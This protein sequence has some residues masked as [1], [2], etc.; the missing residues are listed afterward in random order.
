MLVLQPPGANIPWFSG[1]TAVLCCCCWGISRVCCH[2][3][4]LSRGLTSAP[5]C[6]LVSRVAPVLY[7][8]PWLWLYHCCCC[9]VALITVIT[10]LLA[11]VVALVSYVAVVRR[12]RF[13]C[14]NG[15]ISACYQG[16]AKCEWA[17]VLWLLRLLALLSVMGCSA[18]RADLVT[19]F[20]ALATTL[21]GWPSTPNPLGP[22][23]RPTGQPTVSWLHL[24]RA[25]FTLTDCGP[26]YHAHCYRLGHAYRPRHA[27]L[28]ASGLSR[29]ARIC[30]A[31]VTTAWRVATGIAV[32]QRLLGLLCM[33]VCS[34]LEA[35]LE[36]C[37]CLR[38]GLLLSFV[39][40]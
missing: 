25:A 20:P 27:S 34:V 23:R 31:Y 2:S 5:A 32:L 16:F 12:S 33:E 24:L 3:S 39:P 19:A 26:A 13:Q 40:H 30:H 15:W 10:A 17:A 37:L 6:F 4:R 22:P 14:C 36:S 1:D 7:L 9:T 38:S 18:C 29:E 21:W 35:Q 11:A 8:W 28:A